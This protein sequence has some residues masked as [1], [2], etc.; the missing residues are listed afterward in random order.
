MPHYP[1]VHAHARMWALRRSLL[2]MC[3]VRVDATTAIASAVSWLCTPQ[4]VSLITKHLPSR[5][6]H[7]AAKTDTSIR[8]RTLLGCCFAA[9]ATGRCLTCPRTGPLARACTARLVPSCLV[10]LGF[11]SVAHPPRRYGTHACTTAAMR[12]ATPIC[13]W[14]NMHSIASP[15]LLFLLLLAATDGLH[16]WWW[17]AESQV[18]T[19]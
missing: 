7:V 3:L 8:R 1:S 2:L 14:L 15:L 18:S 9:A 5:P 6:L 16:R 12:A 11:E 17:S 4:P 19:T 13:A 10:M